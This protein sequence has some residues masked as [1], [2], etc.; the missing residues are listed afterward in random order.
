MDVSNN[1][2][3]EAKGASN[4]L[5][6]NTDKLSQA[7]DWLQQYYDENKDVF[8]DEDEFKTNFRYDE[9]SPMQKQV[10]DIFFRQ[11]NSN[12]NPVE[13]TSYDDLTGNIEATVSEPT[14]SDDLFWWQLDKEQEVTPTET[15]KQENVSSDVIKT[16]EKKEDKPEKRNMAE[17]FKSKWL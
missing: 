2:S 9:R 12:K 13:K 6:E 7:L 16:E 3:K 11:L 15:T 10:L 14:Q 5:W 4:Y 8:K 1:P 17:Y